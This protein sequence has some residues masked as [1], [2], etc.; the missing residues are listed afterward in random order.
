[1]GEVDRFECHTYFR[2]CTE[3]FYK[4]IA[5]TFIF[6]AISC[7]GPQMISSPSSTDSE[8]SV[9]TTEEKKSDEHASLVAPTSTTTATSDASVKKP[10]LDDHGVFDDDQFQLKV[11]LKQWKLIQDKDGVQSY[12]KIASNSGLVAFRGEITIPVPLKK[13]ATIL[14]D[15][16]L[17]KDWVDALVEMRIVSQNGELEHVQYNQTR[18]PWPFQNRDFVIRVSAK[19]NQQPPTALIDMKSVEDP[20]VPPVDGVVRGELIHSYYYLKEFEGA[21]ATRMVVEMEVN[22]KGAIPLW[23]VNLSQKVWPHNTLAAIKKLALREDIPVIAKVEKYFEVINKVVKK[24]GK[25]K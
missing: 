18:V 14:V 11:N 24:K 10:S 8:T 19:I 1:M 23:L 25:K 13:V 9:R 4:L 3:L 12:E 6:S 15:E 16:S 21:K 5:I 22:P 2:M 20:A 17:Q 7:S